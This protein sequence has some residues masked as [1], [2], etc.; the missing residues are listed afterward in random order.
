MS[1]LHGTP[2][3]KVAD[4][5]KEIFLLRG[6]FWGEKWWLYFLL[7][8]YENLGFYSPKYIPLFFFFFSIFV[9]APQIKSCRFM[10]PWA[11]CMC[12]SFYYKISPYFSSFILAVFVCAYFQAYFKTVITKNLW[13]L[14]W[15]CCSSVCFKKHDSITVLNYPIKSNLLKFYFSI[16]P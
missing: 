8:S 2:L 16:V 13:S 6:G 9:P 3:R 15:L 10:I 4:H 12:N 11:F 1:L 5:S 14:I 7:I